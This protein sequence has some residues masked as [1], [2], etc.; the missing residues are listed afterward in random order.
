MYGIKVIYN[1]QNRTFSFEDGQVLYADSVYVDKFQVKGAHIE[2]QT[3]FVSFENTSNGV[4]TNRIELFYSKGYHSCIIPKEIIESGVIIASVEILVE[5]ATADGATPKFSRITNQDITFNCESTNV[6]DKIEG[7][8][9][10]TDEV[11]YNA[12]VDAI[13]EVSAN[14]EQGF[15]GDVKTATIVNSITTGDTI[16]KG[17]EIEFNID[18]SG[19]IEYF[20]KNT[21]R[22]TYLYFVDKDTKNGIRFDCYIKEI[23][24]NYKYNFKIQ[25]NYIENGKQTCIEEQSADFTILDYSN[26]ATAYKVINNFQDIPNLYIY[27]KNSNDNFNKETEGFVAGISAKKINES[28]DTLVKI[29]NKDGKNVEKIPIDNYVKYKTDNENKEKGRFIQVVGNKEKLLPIDEETDKKL[30]DLEN[31]FNG[32]HVVDIK[33]FILDGNDWIS[34][35]E[36]KKTTPDEDKSN[37]I[38]Q[39]DNELYYYTYRNVKS[40]VGFNIANSYFQKATIGGKERYTSTKQSYNR[41]GDALLLTEKPENLSCVSFDLYMSQ[42]TSSVVYYPEISFINERTGSSFEIQF[43]S[44]KGVLQ[45]KVNSPTANQINTGYS[46][47]TNTFADNVKISLKDSILKIYFENHNKTVS[48]NLPKTY[49]NI[50]KEPITNLTDITRISFGIREERNYS[51]P[52]NW[53]GFSN[54]VFEK[55]YWEQGYKIQ[56]NTLYVNLEDNALYRYTSD[57]ETTPYPNFVKISGGSINSDVIEGLS[58]VAKT[59]NYDDLLNKPTIPNVPNWALATNKPTYNYTE[60]TGLINALNGKATTNYVDTKVAGLVDSAPTTLDTLGEI[61]DAL[62]DNKDIVSVLENSISNK[63]DKTTV[64]NIQGQ[65][66]NIN[67]ILATINNELSEI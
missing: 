56:P 49:P 5:I 14:A 64:E 43:A 36:L 35:E 3:M 58:E 61:A 55:S 22:I 66:G 67:T 23:T 63:A 18:K 33:K 20:T 41:G 62:R 4:K 21:P 26:I 27:Y 1:N 29:K 38:A 47:V 8:E 17:D 9:L 37:Y 15:D 13:N 34:E 24:S 52:T 45:L 12:I 28:Q 46:I 6:S 42:I 53:G 65:I 51:I 10:T 11:R 19:L 39:K 54:V 2:G 32:S 50:D 57:S 44:Y 31:K 48:I 16:F 7:A 40:N 60:I 25:I 30:V 59:G